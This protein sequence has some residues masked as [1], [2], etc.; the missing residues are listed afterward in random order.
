MHLCDDFRQ[1]A[2]KRLSVMTEDKVPTDDEL[3][4]FDT[5]NG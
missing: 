4:T 3:K 2:I 1:L 5:W